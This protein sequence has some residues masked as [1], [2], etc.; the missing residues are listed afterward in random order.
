MNRDTI[1]GI[2]RKRAIRPLNSLPLYKTQTA[3]VT[4]NRQQINPPAKTVPA[5]NIDAFC[6]IYIKDDASSSVMGISLLKNIVED[7]WS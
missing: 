5:N 3:P 2:G 1:S 7:C 4:Q 6:L